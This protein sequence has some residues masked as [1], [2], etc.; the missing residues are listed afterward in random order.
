MEEYVSRPNHTPEEEVAIDAFIKILLME[1]QQ[2]PNL[3][4]P[5][6]L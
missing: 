6:K 3:Y 4:G 1:Q 5:K 2:I